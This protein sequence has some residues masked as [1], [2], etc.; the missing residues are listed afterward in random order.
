[1][2]DVLPNGTTQQPKGSI[3]KSKESKDRPRSD[4]LGTQ[5]KPGG[6]KHKIVFKPKLTDVFE[7]ESYKQYNL[8]EPQNEGKTCCQIM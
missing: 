4:S 7:V 6:K 8:D 1:M 5:I 2:A 3:L